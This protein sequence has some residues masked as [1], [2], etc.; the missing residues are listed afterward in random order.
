MSSSGHIYIYNDKLFMKNFARKSLRCRRLRHSPRWES[1]PQP[2]HYE[3]DNFRFVSC[4]A[5]VE[6]NGK[7]PQTPDFPASNDSIILHHFR[8]KSTGKTHTCDG[9]PIFPPDF[10]E[11]P[12]KPIRFF[13]RFHGGFRRFLRIYAESRKNHRISLKTRRIPIIS[14]ERRVSTREVPFSENGG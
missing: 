11:N 4:A 8:L 6:N 2:Q 5:G 14:R 10:S 3:R 12:Y 7:T 9:K 1:N 13:R